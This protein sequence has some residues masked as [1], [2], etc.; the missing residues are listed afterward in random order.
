MKT[1]RLICI[2][3]GLAQAALFYALI[4][5]PE[6]MIGSF[7]VSTNEAVAFVGR[8]AAVLFLG[9]SVISFYSAAAAKTAF[10]T[11]IV[12][13]ISWFAIAATGIFEYQ[14]GYVGNAA[15]PAIGTE[16]LLGTLLLGSGIMSKISQK[17]HTRDL[18]PEGADS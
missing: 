16:L 10:P 17:S 12:L 9:L 8:R 11:A 4:T 18:I 3:S 6:A 13:S 15:F 2:V 5:D 14:R 7:G 1:F